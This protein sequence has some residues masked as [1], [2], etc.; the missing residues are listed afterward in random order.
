MEKATRNRLVLVVVVFSLAMVS[1]AARLYQLQIRNS[2]LFRKMAN[3][4]HRGKVEVAAVRGAILDRN[5]RELAVSLETRSL[6]AHPRRVDG[7]ERLAARIASI[8]DVPSR[9]LLKKL[10][11]DKAF[12]YLRRFMDPE[13]VEKLRAADLPFGTSLGFLPESKRFYPR[14]RLAVHVVGFSTVDGVGVEGI[15][16]QLDYELQGDPT[17]YLLRYDARR[18]AVRQLIDP[19]EKEPRDVILSIDVV[20]QHIAERELDRAMQETGARSASAILMD[21]DSGQILA[22]ANRPAA[23]LGSYGRSTAEERSNR[24]VVHHYEPGSTFKVVSMAAALEHGVVRPTDTFYCH[25]GLLVLGGRRL[26][27]TGS[28]GT[29]SARDILAKSSNIGMVRILQRLDSNALYEA[30]RTFGFGARTGIELP[31]ERDGSL[32]PVS[33]WS[34]LSHDSLSFGQEIGVTVLQM[35]SALATIA[36]DGL[37]HPPRVVL[38]TRDGELRFR[39]FDA[40]EPR[41]VVSPETAR[42]VASMMARVITDGTGTRAVVGGYLAAGKSGTAQKPVAGG[43]SNSDYMASFGGFAPLGEPRLVAMV[44]LDSPAGDWHHG[45]QVAAPV[46]GRIMTDGLRHLRVPQTIDP[47]PTPRAPVTADSRAPARGIATGDGNVP[48][49][50]GL[51]LREATAALAARGYHARVRGNG[52]VVAQKPAAGQPLASGG[53]CDLRLADLPTGAVSVSAVSR[54]SR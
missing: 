52:V 54:G 33:G 30:I 15:E 26:H 8:I 28:H 39:R 29:L 43:Y 1:V 35:T 46:F 21:P 17:S 5:G 10:R 7:P 34:A 41:R 4:Q 38:G 53:T 14:G 48:N 19:P 37:L 23:D 49:L 51:S 45:G 18:G 16:K 42:Q 47:V 25:E 13:T 40:P 12:V 22:L 3:G 50:R 27:D 2:D 11:S 31:G 36:N 20:L 44:V 32:A 6:Y 9:V 24:A